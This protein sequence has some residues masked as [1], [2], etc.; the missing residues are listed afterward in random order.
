MKRGKLLRLIAQVR[1]EALMERAQVTVDTL[2]ID[3][4]T[5]AFTL[6]GR[7]V[8]VGEVDYISIPI[9]ST[10]RVIVTEGVVL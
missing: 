7:R 4:A 2:T 1:Q 6:R 3:Y 9:L 5:K 8:Q 10:D